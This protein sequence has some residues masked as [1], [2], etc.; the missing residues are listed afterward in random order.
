MLLL[1]HV[2]VVPRNPLVEEMAAKTD[3]TP[4]PV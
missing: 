1:E 4:E 2:V 3:D